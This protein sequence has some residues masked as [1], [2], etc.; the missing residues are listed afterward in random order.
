MHEH[1]CTICTEPE[2]CDIEVCDIVED[3]F[4]CKGCAA[5]IE[6]GLITENGELIDEDEDEEDDWEEDVGAGGA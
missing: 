5:D 2:E 4:V 3:S 6:E 1:I